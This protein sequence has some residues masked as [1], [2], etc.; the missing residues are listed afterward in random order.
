MVICILNDEVPGD[1]P[2]ISVQVNKGCGLLMTIIN[3][4]SKRLLP[5]VAVRD[6]DITLRTEPSNFK[7]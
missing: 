3:N 6:V 1:V 4:M 2:K 5:A 7:S